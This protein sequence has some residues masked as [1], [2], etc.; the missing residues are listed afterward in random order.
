MTDQIVPSKRHQ[1]RESW[2]QYFMTLAESIATRSTC[3]RATVGAVFVRN[4]RIIAT[5]YNGSISGDPH[6][7]EVGHLMRDGHCIRTIHAEMNA[8]LQCAANGVS[9]A[10]ATVYVTFYPCLN[11]TKAMIQAGVKRVVYGQPYRNDPYAEELFA[12]HHIIVEQGSQ[13]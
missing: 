13:E 11:C 9:S 10:D 12:T 4:H 5:G 1:S 3:E 7:D 8:I 2:D 6:C